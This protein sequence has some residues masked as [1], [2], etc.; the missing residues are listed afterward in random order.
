MNT[1]WAYV[2]WMRPAGLAV[3]F[4]WVFTG[5]AASPRH[6][7]TF[8]GVLT[9]MMWLLGV[10]GLLLWSGT[11]AING[12]EDDDDGPV[13]LLTTPPPKPRYLGPVG[14][15]LLGLASVAALT[16]GPTAAALVAVAAGLG[17]VYSVRGMPWPRGKDIVGVD[18]AINAL[19]CGLGSVLLG[20]ASTGMP[21][22]GEVV[23]VGLAFSVAVFG[24]FPTSQIF[25]L[26]D[27]HRN[28]TAAVGPRRV[29]QL[30]TLLF[31]L[32]IAM[33]APR[34]PW[35]GGPSLGMAVWVGTTLM[36]AVH[37]LWWS[38]TPHTDAYR[39]MQRQLGLLIV[40]QLAWSLAQL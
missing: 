30:G 14:Y 25:Q 7:T 40:G 23:W 29:L 34:G 28:W 35:S 13:N 31:L 39:R 10:N 1:L 18:I 5:W 9:D 37:S 19:G 22:N 8:E 33:L 17:C 20:W 16:R 12:A 2:A 6:P 26:G 27:G 15:G 4:V 11:N 24:G 36:A 32:H 21:L 3:T 38:Q